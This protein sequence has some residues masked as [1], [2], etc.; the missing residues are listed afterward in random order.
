MAQ[1]KPSSLLGSIPDLSSYEVLYKHFH[2]HPELS[3]QEHETANTVA[4]HLR[5]LNAYNVHT[6]IGGTGVVGVLEN[7]SGKVILLRADMDALPVKEETGLDYA[8]TVTV[9]DESDGNIKPVM[10]ACGHDMHMTCLLA[11]A[12]LMA[13]VRDHW[14]GTLI[15][16]F[17]PNEE[18]GGGAKAM[19]HDGLYDKV[20]VPDYVLGQH[21]MALRA[22]TVGSKIG[23]IMASSD[24]FKVTLFGQ[25]GHGSMPHR[26]IDPAVLAA[27]VVVRLQTIVSREVDPSDMAV[28]TVASLQ[29]GQT[30]N[31]IA[32]KAEIKVDVRTINE[33]TRKRVI[34]AMRR[35]VKAECSASNSPR[36]PII[37]EIASFP[38]TINDEALA[39]TVA[40]S[41][42]DHFDAFHADTDRTNAS[43]DVTILATSKGRPSLYWFLGGIDHQQWDQAER[44]GTTYQTIPVNHSPFFAPAIQPTMKV[45]AEA[46]SLAALT[47]FS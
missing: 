26:T 34:A 16:L 7:G 13:K 9:K 39:N 42:Q 11:A 40:T 19:V 31:I 25:G 18:R 23:T 1:K 44:E 35:I 28:V 5:G 3:L 30:E 22:G 20:P 46:L 2:S 17:Q 4:K 36:E 14:K 32:D 45:G 47:M 10:H 29:A 6:N 43:E 8:S 37:E 15:V 41:F 27:N 33:A 12:E 38:L 24:R 21:V